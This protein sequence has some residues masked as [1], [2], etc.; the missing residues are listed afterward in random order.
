[1]KYLFLFAVLL[2]AQLVCGQTALP[3]IKATSGKVAI[4]DDGFLDKD[5]W[6]LSPKTRPDVYTAERSR[7]TKWVTFYTDIDSI[8]V[9]VTPGSK[10]DFVVLLNG[11]DSCYTRIASAISAESMTAS[12]VVTHDTI[13]FTLTAVNAI[14]VKAV[15][16]NTD[17]LN[18][19]FD[20]SSFDVHLTRDAI[21]KRTSLLANQPDAVAGKVKP[22]Y[23]NLAKAFK[24]QMG[25]LVLTDPPI[26]T[27]NQTAREMDGRFGWN[28]FEG[29][30]VE[31][32]YDRNLIIIH[33]KLPAKL[34]GY[35]KAK[36][37]FV[38][39]F[40][41]IKGTFVLGEKKYTGNFSMDTGS[42][43]AVIIDSGWVAKQGFP[44]DLKLIKTSVLSDP[45]GV[46]YEMKIVEAPV[47]TLN[48]FGTNNIP[49]V[50]L[51]GKLNPVGFE[52]NYLGNGL[53]KRF[54]MVLDFK[55]D[56][57]YLKPNKLIAVP[58]PTSS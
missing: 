41:V 15:L 45:R 28:L 48:G 10:F 9:K 51:S 34:K 57:L 7:K 33:S 17:T 12:S 38:R 25:S 37:E 11:K 13:P 24:L 56:A 19:H 47:F 6:S 16:N 5:A 29:K 22:N 39:S 18:L 43:L 35:T 30:Q 58:Y 32:D 26:L 3:V 36:M 1:M 23:N 31:V 50:I 8:K 14:A 27:T 53:L 20:M 55:K 40:P 2:T 49:T 52:M 21:L 4:K 44:T 42:E 46:K 54:N